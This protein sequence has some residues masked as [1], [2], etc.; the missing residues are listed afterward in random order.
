MVSARLVSLALRLALLSLP[1]W[2]A[3]ASAQS[4]TQV[5][6][7]IN[8][9][10]SARAGDIVGF[11]G[12]YFGDHPTA[13]LEGTQGGPALQLEAVNSFGEV[14]AA[15]RLPANANGPLVVRLGNAHGLSTAVK[16]NA[17][18]GFHLD[19][20]QLAALGRFRVFG[21][22][23]LLPG[24]V[25]TVKVNGR[26]AILDLAG[27]NEHMLVATAPAQLG[28]QA[29]LEVTV[30]NGNGTGASPLD[31]PLSGL[32]GN[33]SDPLALGVG[34]GNA[35]STIAGKT[36][37]ADRDAR[38]AHRLQCNGYDDDTQA[39]QEAI[40]LAG[41]TGGAVVLLP[42]G[43]CRLKG[44]V[45]LQSNVVLQGAGKARTV[46]VYESSYPLLGRAISLAGLRDLSLRN[47]LS[48]MAASSVESALLQNSERVFFQNVGFDLNGGIQMF[49]TGNR[50][51]VI[52]HCEF[53][54]PKN[55]RDNGP[56]VLSD[57][58]GLV[59]THNQIVFANGAP[60]FGRV[61]DAYI[62]ENHF[63]RDVR[64]N[65]DSKGVI[66][67][68]TLD[69]AY[70]VAILNNLFDVLGGPVTNKVRN[71]G[72]AILSEGGALNR[73]E[74]TGYVKSAS[75]FTLY[76]PD[77]R[78][79]MQHFAPSAIPENYGVAIVGGTGN[80]QARRLVS[81]SSGTLGVERAWDIV[82]DSSS[83]YVSFIWGL[84]KAII[85]G[86]HL[87]Q[88]PRGIWLYQSVVR[89]VDILSN[90]IEEGGGIYLRSAQNLREQLFTPLYG[91]KVADN[92]ITNTSSEWPSYIHLAFV[93]MDEQAFG[94]G[95][96]G[97][98]IRNNTLLAN[99][100]NLSLREEESG[101]VEGFVVRARFEGDTQA[102]SK[103][104]VRMLGTVLQDNHCS[105][106]NIGVLVREGAVATVQDGNS[107]S[108]AEQPK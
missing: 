15:F 38:L 45:T 50:N 33:G 36:M 6:I 103:N 102:K 106:C 42:A 55:P 46:L 4:G 34:W 21:R 72:E 32:G 5:P 11:Q 12:A 19:A 25:P 96:T 43:T 7:V 76:D 24:Y 17:A 44:S 20:L 18:S 99:Q 97:V 1:C 56:F 37:L 57:S 49:L 73:S 30:D 62:G 54:Q 67:S 22:N 2:S 94:L 78:H 92:R 88:N 35:F 51:F 65:L 66:H 26:S 82:P 107:N 41:S 60:T 81:Y 9:P 29:A 61:H 108:A 8:S 104:Q 89:D 31:R 27:S 28:A 13:Q 80:G 63:S 98:E 70:R 101:G 53:L 84:E 69:F 95:A 68:L 90:T 75:A 23:L 86:N 40:N 58:A 10:Q 93:R 105:A 3:M 47:G 71:D 59:F 52:E 85:K 87:S 79:R 64:G 83:R 39:L 48:G 91:V 74:N 100:P 16:L 77:V 14:W